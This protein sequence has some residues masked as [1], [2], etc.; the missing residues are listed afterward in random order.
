MIW[1]FLHPLALVLPLS[2]TSLLCAHPIVDEYMW[3]W[4]SGHLCPYACIR[5]IIE[6]PLS[7]ARKQQQLCP[8]SPFCAVL[9]DQRKMLWL[10]LE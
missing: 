6:V 7:P 5:H 2:R 1:W 3:K 4:D 9:P 8:G 10:K